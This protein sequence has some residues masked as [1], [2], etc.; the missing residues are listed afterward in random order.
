VILAQVAEEV[1]QRHQIIR[2]RERDHGQQN[3]LCAPF[4]QSGEQSLALLR[5]AGNHDALA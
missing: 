4:A 2:R 5:G 1:V 3:R